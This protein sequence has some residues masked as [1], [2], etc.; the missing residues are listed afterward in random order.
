MTYREYRER[1]FSR[2]EAAVGAIWWKTGLLL[3]LHVWLLRKQ[4]E[5]EPGRN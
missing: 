4:R 5:T 2:F 1:E 3:G